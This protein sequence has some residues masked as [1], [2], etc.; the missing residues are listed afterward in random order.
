MKKLFLILL[1]LTSLTSF[2]QLQVKKDT[3]RKTDE[4]VML[5]GADVRA[6]LK[7][8]TENIK[9]GQ[10]SALEF[11]DAQMEKIDAKV[12]KKNIQLFLPTTTRSISVYH[13]V[14]GDLEYVFPE[15]LCALCAY[16]MTIT[17]V[18]ETDEHE[19][20][21]E[22]AIVTLLKI[23]SY[24]KKSSVYIDDE[25]KGTTP[26]SITD[27]TFGEHVLRLEKKGYIEKSMTFVINEVLYTL[28]SIIYM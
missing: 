26:L 1:T 8:L 23:N 27:M 18:E 24:P 10:R 14:Y 16:E 17:Y 13:P 2:A 19:S 25:R 9:G 12:S 7:V 15:E 6:S 21:A 5:E 3:F 4:L 22:S 28:Q 20:V 11:F